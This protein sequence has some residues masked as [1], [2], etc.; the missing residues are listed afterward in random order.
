VIDTLV[1]TLVDSVMRAATVGRCTHMWNRI[2]LIV[3]THLAGEWMGEKGSRL[4][5][6]PI[7]FQASLAF[8]LCGLARDVLGPYPYAIFALSVP[9]GMTSLSLLGEL[10]PI[11]RA[12]P[13]ADWIEAQPVRA[14]ELR[15]SRVLVVAILVGA[16]ALGSLLVAALLAPTGTSFAARVVLVVAG[17]AQ[18]FFVAGVLL[19]VTSALG[20]RAEGALVLVH[21]VVFGLV[22][23]G[24]AAGLGQLNVLSEV[25]HAGGALLAYP[26]AWFASWLP[27]VHGGLGQTLALVAVLATLIIFA[28]APFPPTPRAH[29]TATPLGVLLIPLR[30]LATRFWVRSR[31]RA[32]FDL[33]FDALPA[34]RDFVGRTYPLVAVPLAFLLLGAESGTDK[35]E[36]LF[37]LLL[38]AP[39]IYLPMLLLHVPATAT[40]EA[41]WIV[42]CS[43]LEPAD[44]AG[45]ARKAVAVRFLAPLYLALGILTWLRGDPDLALRLTPVAA[46][47]GILALRF[48][49][50]YFVRQPP[51]STAASDLG[52]AWDDSSSGGMFVVAIGAT[53]LA[54]AAWR[55][56]PSPTAAFVI[57]A[58]VLALEALGRRRRTASAQ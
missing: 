32:S 8:V 24:F 4:P 19:C 20:S 41:R 58:V 27:G 29:R 6:A 21:T 3:R 51:L 33:V 7:L 54:I 47:A 30:W 10:A 22:I 57:L 18:T 52:S 5:V 50:D 14:V 38:F 49:W 23:V 48:S 40:P 42:D 2:L 55:L 39:V 56:V 12:D 36:G 28:L 16:L 1:G 17:L 26:P 11:L 15:S 25:E 43:P 37:A 31:E 46:A 53:F 44:E 35:G 9:L 13:A 34:E 45:G